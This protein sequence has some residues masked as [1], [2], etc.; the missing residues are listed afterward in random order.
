MRPLEL[1]RLR[2][3]DPRI[4]AANEQVSIVVACQM[5]GMRVSQDLV[6]SRSRKVFCPFGEVYH[7]DQ[8]VEPAMRLYT[9]GN[10][11]YC[12]ACRQS[13]TPVWLVSQAWGITPT[14][15]ARVLS[16]RASVQLP[17]TRT[18]AQAFAEAA[19]PQVPVKPGM[20]AD[21]LKTYCG[22]TDPEW[23]THQFEPATAEALGQCL[24]LLPL[25]HTEDEAHRW[26]TTSKQVMTSVKR[27]LD[28]VPHAP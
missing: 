8:G 24:R 5:I 27:S 15:A 14:A 1:R 25:V 10:H 16:E 26:L 23:E 28:A 19:T 17:G 4:A 6:R 20:L 9:D 3:Q 2:K 21:A 22:R 18:M 12:F 7:S 13:F 11:A